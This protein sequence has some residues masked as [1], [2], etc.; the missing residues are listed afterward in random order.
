MPELDNHAVRER[1]LY[2]YRVLY[3][4]D[5]ETI[6]ILAVIHGRRLLESLGDRFES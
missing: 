2:S 1:F 5:A 6:E 3:E 4:W